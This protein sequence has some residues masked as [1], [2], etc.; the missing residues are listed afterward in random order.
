MPRVVLLGLAVLDHRIWVDTWPPVSG[1]TP[2]TA[3]VE[4]LGGGAAVA[5][6]TVARL[7]GTAIFAGPRGGDPAG[8]RVAAALES[9]GVDTR[10]MSVAAAGKTAV[11][12]IVIVPGGERFIC[13][14]PGE[15]LHDDPAWAPIAALEGAGA[16]LVDSRFPRAGQALA[17]AARPAGVPVV[18]DFSD[19]DTAETRA[20]ARAA[21]HVV[22]DEE[23]ARQAGGAGAL[24]ERLRA[25]GVWGAVTLGARGVVHD[26]GRV[27]AFD[28]A[29]RD[30]TGAGDVFHGA[31]TLSLGEGCDPEA[32]LRFA[33]AAAALRC[34]TGGVPD[35]TAVDRLLAGGRAA[36]DG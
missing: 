28:V 21:T 9:Y 10:F 11:S 24:L 23:M 3:Y 31:F 15:A 14:Y 16:V 34:E 27:P 7:G 35:R 36:R 33:S 19:V 20:L 6:A 1:R 25:D 5:A 29:A 8:V 30:T 17:A 12:S 18:M 22:A 13:A 4:D 26:G 32:A 2:A